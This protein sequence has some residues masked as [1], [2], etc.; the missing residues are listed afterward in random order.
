MKLLLI[1]DDMNLAESIIDYF[2][3]M[4]HVADYA[5]SGTAGVEFVRD[6]QYDAVIL[7][8]NLPDS[9]G[10]EIC[11][12]IRSNMRL[13]IPIIMVTSRTM[14]EDKI[15]GFKSGADDYLPKPFDLSELEMRLQAVIRRVNNNLTRPFKVGDLVLDS[16]MRAVSRA[17]VQIELSPVCFSILLKLMEKSP[18]YVT[19]EELEYAVWKDEPPVTDSLKTHLYKLRCRIDTPF[20]TKLLHTTKKKGFR[21]AV[22]PDGL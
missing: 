7:D 20:K 9:D 6:N 8:I 2:T 11:D 12:F 18:K 22:D 1:E 10:F 3:I 5:M 4:G 17:G 13:D 19:K 14:L 15:S 21:L 16:N